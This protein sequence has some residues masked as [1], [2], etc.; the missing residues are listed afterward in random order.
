MISGTG[1]LADAE[2]ALAS[3]EAIGYPVM[4]K[5][6]AGGGGIG[7][8]PCADARELAAAF[9]RVQRLAAASFGAGGVF[10]ERY[11]VDARHVEVQVFG[12]GAGR[13]LALGDRD[14]SLQRRH[15]KVLEEAPAPRLPAAVREAL[16]ASAAALCSAADYRSAGTVEFVY[17]AAREEASFLEVNARLQVEHPV[18]EEVLGIDLVAWML[19]LAQG[20]ASMV[21]GGGQSPSHAV[22]ARVYAEDPAFD[23]RPSAGLITAVAFPDELRVDTWVAAGTEVTTAYD[24]LLAKVIATGATR[25]EALDRL[26]DGLARTRIDGIRTNLGLLRA[27]LADPRVRAA[28]HSTATLASIASRSCAPAR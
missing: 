22:E 4:L 16:H 17:D 6:T 18:T 7:M 26:A 5:A 1:L 19:R 14:C 25:A 24:P 9:A 10:L 13:V 3:A 8:A 27:A 15:Q 12:D 2:A 28:E 11:V 23:Y 20:D 21:A